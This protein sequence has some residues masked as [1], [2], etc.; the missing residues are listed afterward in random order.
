ML[1]AGDEDLAVADLAGAR[2][3]DDGVDRALDLVVRDHDL[4]LHL[5]QEIDHVLGAAIELGV[6]LLAAEPL[7][8]G[9]RESGDPDFG[10]RFAHFVEL[11]R[12]DDRFDLLHGGPLELGAL[13]RSDLDSVR[14]VDSLAGV[15]REEWNALAGEQPF[16]RHEFLSALVDTGCAAARSGW[17]PQFV[18]LR[19]AGALVG[20]L[21]LFAKSHSYGEYVFDWAWAEA[22]ERHGIDYYPKLVSAIP[23]TPV[24]GARIL[25]STPIK[26]TLIQ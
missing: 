5:R 11:E 4:D 14:I 25:G 17:A 21:P 7:H 6:A 20:A 16:V 15:D 1:Y 13:Y 3:F 18:L 12:F 24:R 8:L 19:R 10:Q 9:D 23:F 2:R 22:H 26:K